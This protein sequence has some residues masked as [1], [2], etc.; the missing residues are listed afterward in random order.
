MDWNYLFTSFEGRISRQPFW[1]GAVLLWVINWVAAAILYG[2]FGE[3]FANILFTIVS[4]VLLYPSLAVGA[5]R[6]HDRDKSAWWL[7]IVLIP[8]VG[9]LWYLIECGFLR[10]TEGENRYGPDPLA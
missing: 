3:G 6:W 7:L 9:A 8:V 4:L 1:I 10:G 5:K 2:L